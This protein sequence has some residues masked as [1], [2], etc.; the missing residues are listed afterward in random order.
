[1]R[2]AD[3]LLIDGEQIA[4]RTRQHWLALLVTGRDAI[5]LWILGLVLLVGGMLLN[6]QAQ[7]A[8][9][10]GLAVLA[11]FAI[12]LVIFAI[13]LWQWWAQDYLITNRRLMKVWGVFNKRSVD[14]ALEK[15]NDARLDQSLLGRIFNYGHLDILTASTETDLDDYDMISD[16]KGFKRVMLTQKHALEMSYYRESPSPPLTAPM[17]MNGDRLPEPVV[18][19]PPPGSPAATEV[20]ASDA[21]PLPAPAAESGAGGGHGDLSAGASASAGMDQPPDRSLEITQT[22]SRLADLRDRGAITPEDYEAKKR[23]LL[24]RL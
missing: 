11:L 22:L 20:V 23:E 16:P 21:G 15:V 13:R 9:L 8:Q 3:T 17:D 24:D 10:V 19:P 14:S 6:L 18:P 4:L 7:P 12:G 1:M 2:Y 5:A